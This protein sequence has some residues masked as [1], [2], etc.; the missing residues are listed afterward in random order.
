MKNPFVALV[1]V[2]GLLLTC[3]AWGQSAAIA[4]ALAGKSADP[5]VGTWRLLR[6]VDTPD[7][8]EPIY[9]FGERP[10]GQFLFTKEG[11]FSINIMRNPPAPATATVDIDPDACIPVWY[12][13]YFGSYKLANNGRQWITHVDGGNIPSYIDT[14]QT[15]SFEISGNRMIILETYEEGGRTVRAQR[16]LERMQPQ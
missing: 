2:T 10:V 7:G 8:A 16:V 15:R 4:P 9:A 1:L 6:Y 11:H 5:L 14:S 3:S 12:C 13:S